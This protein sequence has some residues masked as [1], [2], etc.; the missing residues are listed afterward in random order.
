MNAANKEK[1]ENS[2]NSC[3]IENST[4]KQSQSVFMFDLNSIK[5]FLIKA[6]TQ[7]DVK[8][9]LKSPDSTIE[10]KNSKT[11]QPSSEI[12]ED[13]VIIDKSLFIDNRNAAEIAEQEYVWFID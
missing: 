4:S 2:T 10:K 9:K 11:T 7:N 13:F 8:E 12:M 6:N 1:F 3:I 5:Q